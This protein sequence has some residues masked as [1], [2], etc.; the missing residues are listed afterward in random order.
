MLRYLISCHYIFL[1]ALLNIYRERERDMSDPIFDQTTRDIFFPE[2]I[3]TLIRSINVRD[4]A[5]RRIFRGRADILSCHARC[6]RR[7]IVTMFVDTT[8]ARFPRIS[9]RA[10]VGDPAGN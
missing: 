5:Q 8:R 2:H 6:D 3:V 1:S 4:S 10:R 9:S 7:K